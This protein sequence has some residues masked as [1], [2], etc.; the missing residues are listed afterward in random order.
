MINELNKY[1]KMLPELLEDEAQWD[2]LLIDK[3]PPV[4][5]RLSLPVTD[6]LTLVLHKLFPCP[7]DSDAYI[8]SHSWPFALKIIR[9]EY[10]MGV[11]FSTNR[12][13]PPPIIH[14][15]IIG[16]GTVYEMSSSDIWHYTKPLSN[17]PSYS[18]MLIGKRWRPREAQN[19]APLSVEQRKE[20]FDFFRANVKKI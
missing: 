14:K 20:V 17:E 9:G 4:I 18:V 6:E 10:E 7:V 2:S 19:I 11:G 12:K 3:Y 5:Y 13:E 15:I 16:S 1:L 8:H